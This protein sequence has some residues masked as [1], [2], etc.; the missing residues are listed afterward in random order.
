M[1]RNADRA[2]AGHG[3]GSGTLRV[4]SHSRVDDAIGNPWIAA[5]ATTRN[6]SAGSLALA[7]R[8][9]TTSPSWATTSR[10]SGERLVGRAP[11]RRSSQRPTAR[12]ASSQA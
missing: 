3:D 12:Q 1:V 2:P 10:S 4:D 6:D 9:R 7:A 11:P 8:A 5:A